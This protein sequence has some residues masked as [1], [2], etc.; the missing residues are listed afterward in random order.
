ML[1]YIICDAL[2]FIDNFKLL[3]MVVI[4]LLVYNRQNNHQ[5]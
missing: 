5:G 4:L 1:E 2:C 3:I